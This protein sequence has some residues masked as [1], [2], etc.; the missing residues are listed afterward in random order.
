MTGMQICTIENEVAYKV[1]KTGEAVDLKPDR[2]NPMFAVC[3]ESAVA[4]AHYVKSQKCAAA[5]KGNSWYFTA[6]VIPRSV[7]E[8]IIDASGVHR[9]IYSEDV[10]FAGNGIVVL[11]TVNGGEKEIH[12]PCGTKLKYNLEP[13]TTAVFDMK[14]FERIL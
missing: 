1:D 7:A 2:F 12:Y 10:V 14:T 8:Q 3:D 11:S 13:M 5:H 9:Y 6:P 4:V